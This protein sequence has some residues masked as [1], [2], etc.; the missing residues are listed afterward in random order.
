MKHS[1]KV[2]HYLFRF[3]QSKEDRVRRNADRAG[4]EVIAPRVTTWR[5]IGK[6]GKPKPVGVPAFHSYLILGFEREQLFV[7]LTKLHRSVKPLLVPYDG[8]NWTLARIPQREIDAIRDCRHF[9]RSSARE[10][11][12]EVVPDPKFKE[13]ELLRILG[14]SMGGLEGKVIRVNRDARECALDMG[15]I[16]GKVTVAYDHLERAA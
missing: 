6:R 7:A 16:F 2:K 5:R 10:L 3:D 13:S 9:K 11:V 12:T 1:A 15:G 4:I 14:G 8:E